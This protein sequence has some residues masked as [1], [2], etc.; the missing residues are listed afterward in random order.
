MA[1]TK[2]EMLE[3]LAELQVTH[4]P[5]T[6]EE[7]SDR[8]TRDELHRV[9]IRALSEAITDVKE[10]GDQARAVEAVIDAWDS[11]DP[12]RPRR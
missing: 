8:L 9:L 12:G 6:G 10:G 5:D 4:H 11:H 1:Q 2:A 3:R 7:L